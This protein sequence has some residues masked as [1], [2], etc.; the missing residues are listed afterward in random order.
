MSIKVLIVLVLTLAAIG[1][2]KPGTVPVEPPDAAEDMWQHVWP[3]SQ[4]IETILVTP[5]GDVFV[6]TYDSALFVSTDNG[7]TFF[8]SSNGLFPRDDVHA[9]AAALNGFLYL[10]T[11]GGAFY[12]STD[13]GSN[14]IP[15][16]LAYGTYNDFFVGD[17]GEVFAAL[18]G[19]GVRRT[20]NDG[21]TWTNFSLP[22]SFVFTIVRTNNGNLIAGTR[23][24]L[25]LS[26][27]SG[28]TWSHNLNGI[29]SITVS[30]LKLTSNG[31]VFA[32]TERGVIRSV[33]NGITWLS[34]NLTS[35]SLGILRLAVSINDYIV[36]SNYI[37]GVYI[38]SDYGN[39]WTNNVSGMTDKRVRCVA[40]T[41]DGY[42]FAGTYHSGIFRTKKPIY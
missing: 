7:N 22:D 40:V 15:P 10:G 14:W 8:Q 39:A 6:G 17:T 37:N 2:K 5:N 4:W 30:S 12:L 3:V 21:L 13:H 42:V 41:P 1:C 16:S 24:G 33:D 36:A 29:Q 11:Y 31:N 18:L 32:A 20:T 34:T 35:D 38:S 9:L 25:Y 27:D 26:A 23:S 19:N 28:T